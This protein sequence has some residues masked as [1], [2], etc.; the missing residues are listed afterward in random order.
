MAVAEKIQRD[1]EACFKKLMTDIEDNLDVRNRDKFTHS[2][3]IFR[4]EMTEAIRGND[5][6]WNTSAPTTIWVLK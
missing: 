4:R 5:E 2:L 6:I 1:V 3:T